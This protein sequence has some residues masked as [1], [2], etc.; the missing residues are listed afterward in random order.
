MKFGFQEIVK[1]KKALAIGASALL[2]NFSSLATAIQPDTY[3]DLSGGYRVDRFTTLWKTEGV[4]P[5]PDSDETGSDTEDFNLFRDKIK[6]KGLGIWTFGG[7]GQIRFCDYWVLKGSAYYGWI[8]RGHYHQERTDR[9]LHDRVSRSKVKNG[10][11]RDA[12]IGFGYMYPIRGYWGCQAIG[13]FVGYS[14]ND[15]RYRMG[16]F[17][18]DGFNNPILKDLNYASRWNGPWIGI[19]YVYQQC[20]FKVMSSLEYHWTTWHGEYRLQRHDIPGVEFSKRFQADNAYGVVWSIDGEWYFWDNWHMG[21]EYKWQFWRTH[22]GRA[23]PKDGNIRQLGFHDHRH[24]E[25]K[26]TRWYSDTFLFN[27]GWDW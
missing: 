15:Q 9:F 14:Y 19:D 7:K 10:R 25:L 26:H 6:I 21:L 13:P 17:T 24:M 22:Q 27:I 12:Q 5:V 20:P 2:L 4:N 16:N 18:T 8:D 3:I 23:R 1:A 11:T